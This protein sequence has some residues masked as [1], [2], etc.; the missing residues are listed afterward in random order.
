MKILILGGGGLLGRSV[1]ESLR[2]R[3]FDVHSP[4]K[5]ILDLSARESLPAYLD[6]RHFDL[7]V[8]CAG[9]VG[10]IGQNVRHPFRFARLNLEI[11]INTQGALAE[12]K[13]DCIT[14][15][16]SSM[17]SP[18]IPTPYS[19]DVV[20]AGEPDPGNEGYSLA[21]RMSAKLVKLS[22]REFGLNN[23]MLVLSNI[24]GPNDHLDLDRAHLPA[25]AILKTDIA[26]KTGAPVTVW[27]SGKAKREF[28]YVEDVSNWLASNVIDYQAMPWLLNIGSGDNRPVKEFY[29]VASKLLS[30]TTP[31]MFDKEKPEGSLSKVLDSSIAREFFKW[32]PST[33]LE[34]GMSRC[35]DQWKRSGDVRA[36]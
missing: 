20:F 10:G 18:S 13:I 7:V 17:Y 32:S 35:V 8:N 12:S 14:F 4:S 34:E 16:T 23:R 2:G 28:T 15:G 24:Y 25:A 27:G 33:T 9:H 1:V 29:E 21:K 3:E 30:H 6:N 31:M 22:N 5:N 19:E 36:E 11:E 26:A